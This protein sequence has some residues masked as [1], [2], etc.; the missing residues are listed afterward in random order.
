MVIQ[1]EKYASKQRAELK[2]CYSVRP[3]PEL[4]ALMTKRNRCC[5]TE[6]TCQAVN[7]NPDNRIIYEFDMKI[8]RATV[9][10]ACPTCSDPSMILTQWHGTPNRRRFRSSINQ[11]VA[12]LSFDDYSTICCENTE[13]YSCKNGLVMEK[14]N[15]AKKDLWSFIGIEQEQGGKPRV[16]TGPI[17]NFIFEN[18]RRKNKKGAKFFFLISNLKSDFFYHYYFSRL[19]PF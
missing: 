10:K 3:D 8:S 5:D 12:D 16:R 9:T 7:H 15:S 19:K 4:L 2:N 1:N 14:I 18:F 17:E 13:W 6:I 11:C